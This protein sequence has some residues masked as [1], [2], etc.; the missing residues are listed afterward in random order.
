MSELNN[1]ASLIFNWFI[2]QKL[3]KNPRIRTFKENTIQIKQLAL[4]FI[5]YWS[6]VDPLCEEARHS[7]RV[8]Q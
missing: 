6:G 7:N 2:F 4:S 5:C 1:T 3:L 8:G